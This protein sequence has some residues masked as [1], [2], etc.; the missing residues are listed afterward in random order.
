[1]LQARLFAYGD[2]HRYRL[3]I[4]H[5]RLP[6][7]APRGVPGGARNYG[8]DGAMRF[9]D[10]GGRSSSYEPNG[11]DGPS[12]TGEAMYG[13]FA[14]E[15]MTGTFAPVRHAE[16]DDFG[17][18]GALYRL[19]SAE[20][21]GRLVDALAGSLAQVRRDDVIARSISHF[22]AADASL[23]ARLDEAVQTRRAGR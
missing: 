8:R 1:M 21:Q 2:A 6:I 22:R 23:G 18:A 3:G 5:T 19:M 7:N 17:Q 12:E 13:G 4:N 16:D 9:D 20:E 15:G 10:N 14:L 11:Y